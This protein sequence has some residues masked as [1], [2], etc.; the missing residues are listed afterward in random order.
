[1]ELLVARRLEWRFRNPWQVFVRWQNKDLRGMPRL[2]QKAA[3]FLR[4]AHSQLVI[5]WAQE[6]QSITSRTPAEPQPPTELQ[7]PIESQTMAQQ[8]TTECQA[9]TESQTTTELQLAID[10]Q[11]TDATSAPMVS[12]AEGND[13][14]L[15]WESLNFNALMH[16]VLQDASPEQHIAFPRDFAADLFDDNKPI[17]EAPTPAVFRT[18][19]QT[20]V[21]VLRRAA[22]TLE[23]GALEHVRDERGRRLMSPGRRRRQLVEMTTAQDLL[24]FF[25]RETGGPR[26]DYVGTLLDLTFPSLG[27]GARDA[28]GSEKSMRARVKQ[29]VKQAR[30]PAQKTYS[31]D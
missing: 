7:P 29:L 14:V 8:A 9:A 6:L 26:Y 1:L 27:W 24:A 5:L 15:G 13:E 20:A 12:A 22:A 31:G 3:D 23:H 30:P 28:S 11:R 4:D 2:L 21:L 25:E 18:Q 16:R 10:S 17:G 19:I